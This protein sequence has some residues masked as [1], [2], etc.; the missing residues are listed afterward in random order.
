[1]ML[2]SCPFELAFS[3]FVLLVS[4][5]VLLFLSGVVVDSSSLPLSLEE[6]R[7][8]VRAG[9]RPK[10]V[11]FW[12]DETRLRRDVV[13]AGCLSQWFASPFEVRGL[14][15]PTAEHFMMAE[16]ARLFGDGEAER[17]V[18]ASSNPGAAKRIGRGVRGFSEEVWIAHRERIVLE[19]SVA[20]FGQSPVLREYLVGT[21]RRVLVEASPVDKIWGI[22]LAADHEHAENPLLWP[23]LNLLGFAL[24]AARSQL[25]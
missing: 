6:L 1:L 11:F 8:R 19:A 24:M 14:R 17:A 3:K 23:G 25:A 2:R 9:L 16:K 13:G 15:Y 22:G 12:S 20:K 18:M 5:S 21:K 4:R 7:S 10:Y